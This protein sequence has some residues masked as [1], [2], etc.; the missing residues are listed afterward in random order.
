MQV[1]LASAGTVGSEA[2]FLKL[3]LIETILIVEEIIAA[4]PDRFFAVGLSELS[5]AT[6]SGTGGEHPNFRFW[7]GCAEYRLS[8][9]FTRAWL[10]S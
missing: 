7:L 8:W 9:L 5:G 4:G 2:W 6:S 10:G 1:R 3:G